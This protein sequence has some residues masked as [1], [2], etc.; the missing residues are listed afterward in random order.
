MRL[1]S[2]LILLLTANASFADWT[3]DKARS[4]LSFI[5]TK[6]AH[7]A[8]NHYFH[9]ISGSVTDAGKAQLVIQ[10]Q[11]VETSIDIRDK[12]LR[13]IL[14]DVEKYPEATANLMIRASLTKPKAPG[15]S[16]ITTISGKLDMVGV[17]QLISAKVSIYHLADGSMEVSS[18][19]PVLVDSEDFGMLPAINKLRDMAGLNT[20]S[21]KIPV[22]FRLVFQRLP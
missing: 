9:D 7:V 6:D 3:L 10:T 8:D 16:K 2:C 4:E 14:F 22:S 1:L 18:V 17:Q 20:I 19:E 13:S 12:R 5:A 15:S 11:S 21:I